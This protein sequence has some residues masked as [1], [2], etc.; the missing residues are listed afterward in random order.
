MLSLEELEQLSRFAAGE[1]SSEESLLVQKALRVRPDLQA[2]LKRLQ[3]LDQA[4]RIE[5]HVVADSHDTGA[6]AHAIAAR[7]RRKYLGPLAAIAATLLIISGGVILLRTVPLPGGG[8]LDQSSPPP[9]LIA[10]TDTQSHLEGG[11]TVLEQGTLLV[12]DRA[13][14]SSDGW[15]IE[16]DGNAVVTTEPLTAV[17]RV[18]EAL[19]QSS[20]TR[21]QQMTSK[22]SA[23]SL[24]LTA[25]AGAILVLAQIEG[26]ATVASAAGE[27]HTVRAGEVWTPPAPTT[28]AP[29]LVAAPKARVSDEHN[30]AITEPQTDVA[31]IDDSE[32]PATALSAAL[33]SVMPQV[34]A[35]A[36]QCDVER[37]VGQFR[38]SATILA[39]G[40]IGRMDQATIDDD[41]SI[42]NP[43]LA[44]CVIAALATADYPRPAS[45]SAHIHLPFLV[46]RDPESGGARIDAPHLT[47][48]REH[49]PRRVG[50]NDALAG[51]PARGPANAEITVIEFQ[52]FECPFCVRV[53]DTVK[54]IEAAYPG[55]VRV[56]FRQRPM[57]FHPHAR[58]A[59][60]A[61]LAAH[62]QGR[63]W[64]YQ[65]LLFA[66]TNAL[67]R[68]SLIR[69]ARELGLDLQRFESALD[70]PAIAAAVDADLAEAKRIGAT[71]VP[72]FVVN[73]TLIIGA[74]PFEEFAKIVDASLKEHGR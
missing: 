55:R 40:E 41:Y 53:G 37:C 29:L 33:A 18:M 36:N 44:G 10:T 17:P 3:R 15:Q 25:A 28:P 1:L 9:A 65:E 4:C 7:A 64:E 38:V 6:I 50:T 61:A 12:L 58:L 60:L 47:T 39:A 42:Q 62:A 56:I 74:Q 19:G 70:D 54:K 66:N 67:D 16:I 52:D 31:W 20:D 63:F 34:S 59:A 45:D 2:G 32:L 46:S 22:L 48:A 69:F 68:S 13:S 21:R 26:Y 30:L 24:P 73:G 14:V 35:C 5:S 27:L 72:S 51:L 71:G 49:A 23:L 8:A 57:P 43:T 11:H